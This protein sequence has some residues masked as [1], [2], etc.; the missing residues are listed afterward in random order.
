MTK[1]EF[2]TKANSTRKT[3]IFTDADYEYYKRDMRNARQAARRGQPYFATRNAGVV[4][5]S[6]KYPAYTA[7]YTVYVEAEGP[8]VAI[9]GESRCNNRRAACQY[10]MGERQYL[11]EFRQQKQDIAS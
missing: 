9:V 1:R 11:A 2:F 6:Y 8:V 4:P 7:A 5:S 3:R 10:R